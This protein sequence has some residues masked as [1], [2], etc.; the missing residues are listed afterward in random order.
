MKDGEPTDPAS[1]VELAVDLHA[2][3]VIAAN[4]YQK[5]INALW[6]GYYNVQYSDND[7]LT[8]DKYRYL[9]SHNFRD[10]F[11]TQRIKGPPNLYQV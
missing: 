7:R 6:R 10:H 9:T 3:R 11:D 4:N 5:C 2:T 8:F 1:A